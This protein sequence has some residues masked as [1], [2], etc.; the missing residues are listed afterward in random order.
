MLK[1]AVLGVEGYLGVLGSRLPGGDPEGRLP[2]GGYLGGSWGVRLPGGSPRGAQIT[3][4][5]MGGV[6]YVGGAVLGGA[7]CPEELPGGPG[8]SR[9]PRGRLPGRGPGGS[10]YLENPGGAGYLE[11]NSWG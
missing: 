6:G 4:R 10:G 9:L 1:G 5:V 2:E 3:W 11:E 8:E 7:G